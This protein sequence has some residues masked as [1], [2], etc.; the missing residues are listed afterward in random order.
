MRGAV[1]YLLQGKAF[2]GETARQSRRRMSPD[3]EEDAI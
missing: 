3:A 1:R 2:T